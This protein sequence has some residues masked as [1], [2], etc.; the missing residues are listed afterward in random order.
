MVLYRRNDFIECIQR[1]NAAIS[2]LQVSKLTHELYNDNEPVYNILQNI[3][4]VLASC[5]LKLYHYDR[6]I[7]LM[8]ELLQID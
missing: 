7:G 2:V 6:P 4:L 3:Y 1:L 5:E 8:D